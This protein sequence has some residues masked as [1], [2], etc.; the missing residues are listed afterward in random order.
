MQ[1]T[2]EDSTS[3]ST[4]M[5]WWFFPIVPRKL[6]T[7]QAVE[8]LEQA[9]SF[10][11]KE[12]SQLLKL[13]LLDWKEWL[14]SKHANS[15]TSQIIPDQ[16]NIYV[17]QEAYSYRIAEFFGMPP[18]S[19]H[20]IDSSLCHRCRLIAPLYRQELNSNRH[21]KQGIALTKTD[22]SGHP[23]SLKRQLFFFSK[24]KKFFSISY[25]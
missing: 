7:T 17:H 9:F 15:P 14:E 6:K 16:S 23:K 21:L 1:M 11:T 20:R 8:N 24:E 12:F 13:Q 4:I 3:D 5:M 2:Q 22:I 18:R 19:K 25:F 10:E